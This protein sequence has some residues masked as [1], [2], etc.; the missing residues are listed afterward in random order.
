[1]R[2]RTLTFGQVRRGA[3]SLR[4]TPF[5]PVRWSPACRAFPA[6]TR[7]SDRTSSY[8]ATTTATVPKDLHT[9]R[10]TPQVK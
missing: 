3:G 9:V 4:P 7:S 8:D 1:M 10:G 6:G 2:R 5:G